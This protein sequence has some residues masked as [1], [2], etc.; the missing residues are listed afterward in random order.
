MRVVLVLPVMGDA[1]P[2]WVVQRSHLD[3][4]PGN[5]VSFGFVSVGWVW[6]GLV[7]FGLV[8]F[9]LVLPVMGDTCL[10]VGGLG[11]PAPSHLEEFPGNFQPVAAHHP[12]M[13]SCAAPPTIV[14]NQR[15]LFK[16]LYPEV[17]LDLI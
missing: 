10:S 9:G 6:F 13:A 12:L 1:C 2:V 3:E 7:W 16:A 14:Q 11:D 4:F 15:L 17:I 8:R 5:L